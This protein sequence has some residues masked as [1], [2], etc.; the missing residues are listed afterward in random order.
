MLGFTPFVL[1]ALATVPAFAAP[2]ISAELRGQPGYGAVD[3]P[4]Q[5]S[6][7]L[8][9]QS[10]PVPGTVH[11]VSF[12]PINAL[13]GKAVKREPLVHPVSFIPVN[14]LNGE[15]RSFSVINNVVG[16]IAQDLLGN[17]PSK[18]EFSAEAPHRIILP[19]EPLV[20][21]VSF[22]PVNALNS[23]RRSFSVIDHVVGSIAQDL[24]GNRPSKR[25][26]NGEGPHHIILPREPLVRPV[27]FIPVNALN[28]EA[29]SKRSFSAI[30][31]IV[32]SI[33]ED[34]LGPNSAK[35][36]EP[37]LVTFGSNPAEG[38]HGPVVR[39]TA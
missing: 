28:N 38:G 22:I 10:A 7:I 37:L 33:A 2:F 6:S 13:N 23:E 8:S 26:I 30:N 16:S 20:H 29:V 39:P 18:R 21:P 36:D 31:H 24:L 11:P 19:R 3:I 15:K 27:S 25:N 1:A 5:G 32:G 14:A 35:R 4:P 12:I 9:R 34:I 17:R